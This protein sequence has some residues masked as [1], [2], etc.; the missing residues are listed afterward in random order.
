MRA[1]STNA[2]LE[3]ELTS[4]ERAQAE[5]GWQDYLA[6]RSKPLEQVM[7][8]ISVAGEDRVDR[9]SRPPCRQ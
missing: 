1:H 8:E 5:A 3:E 7:R 2:K 9:C 6:G 4:F